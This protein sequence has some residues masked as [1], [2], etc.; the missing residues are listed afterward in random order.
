[1]STIEIAAACHACGSALAPGAPFCSACGA[2][3]PPTARAAAGG[4]VASASAAALSVTPAAGSVPAPP[5]RRVAALLVDHLAA[6]VVVVAAYAVLIG[7][8]NAAIQGGA[9][10]AA[11]AGAWGLLLVPALVQVV[12]VVAQLT[13]EGRAGKTIGN[14]ALGIRTVSLATGRPPGFGRAFGRRFIE[15]LGNIVFVGAYVIAGS[16]AWDRPTKRQGWQ[17]K[18]VGTAMVTAASFGVAQTRGPQTRGAQS[19]AGA[20]SGPSTAGPTPA[21]SDPVASAPA[22]AGPI[23]AVPGMS[24]PEPPTPEP[25]AA[26]VTGLPA[27]AVATLPVGGLIDFVPGVAPA[28]AEPDDDAR[29]P[30]IVPAP[31]S[32]QRP[33]AAPTGRRAAAPAPARPV[34]VASAP[35]EDLAEDLEH[36]AIRAPR[37]LHAAAYRL[38]F[39]TGEALTITGSGLVGRNPAPAAGESADHVIPIADPARSVSKT[40][41][42]FGVG[43]D[44]FW[45]LDRGSTNGTWTVTADGARS[46]APPGTPVTVPVGSTVEFG[47]RR[48]TV[49]AP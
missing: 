49:S 43:P 10:Q 8:T 19:P 41:L 39:D 22:L 38:Q 47:D 23:A 1:M 27:P 20:R 42:A 40:H 4:T 36:T 9:D 46:D 14:A 29:T 33:G 11:V 34:P 32:A 15:G 28:P 5:G 21:A 45:V 48:F 13:W 16:S 26:P 30:V 2:S 6:A 25:V 17:D 44:G 35:F 31:P 37:P 3:L 18:A 12:F 24:E 7:W